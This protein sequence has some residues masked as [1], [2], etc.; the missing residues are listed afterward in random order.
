MEAL[1]DSRANEA[2]LEAV[3]RE[4]EVTGGLIQRLVDENATRKLDQYDYRK[5]YDRY[6]GRYAALESREDSLEKERERKEIQYDIFSGFGSLWG[7][8]KRRSCRWTLTRNC[9]TGLWIS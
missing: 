2:E 1:A 9:S 7:L 8:A 3:S 4:K 6:A 5:K